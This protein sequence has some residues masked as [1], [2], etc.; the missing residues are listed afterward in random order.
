MTESGKSF[1]AE[2]INDAKNPVVMFALEWC[3]FCW[4]VRKLFAELNIPYKAYDLDSV[5]YQQGGLGGE[6]RAALNGQIGSNTIPQ[7]FI[8]GEHM[9]G[10]TDTF[11]AYKTGKLQEH[12][13]RAGIVAGDLGDRD[14]F[15]LLPNWLH[16]R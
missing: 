12:L 5:T 4:A 3:E 7:I 1:V 16:K 8:G 13:A 2:A 6:I 10:G 9:G 11:E 14:P 15:E